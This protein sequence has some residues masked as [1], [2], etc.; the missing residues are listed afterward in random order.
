MLAAVYH[1]PNDIRVENVP[2]PKIGKGELLV[3]VL[4]ASIC[5][6]DLRIF[7]GSHRMYTP[8]TIRIPG[9]EVVGT[10]AEAG[11]EVNNYTIGQR[12]FCAPNT[13]CGRC[14]Q[15]VTGDNNLCASYDAIGVTSDGGFAEYVRIPANSVQQGN[16]IPVSETIDPAVAALMEPF[17]CVL[18]GQNALYIK[19]GEV[20]LIIGAGPIGVMHTKLAKARGA[21]RVIVSEPI[22]ERAAQVKRMGAD[23]VVD[24]ATEDLKSVLLQESQ[25]RGA[26]VIIVAAP[27][28]VAQES[29]L[30]LAAISGRI[31][32]FG[33]LPKDRPTINFDSNLVHY[34]EL[35]ITATT[36]CSTADCWQATQIIN[37]GLVDLS[38]VVSQRFPLKDAVMAF[39]A[40][41][42]R[43]SLKIILEP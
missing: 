13:G 3:K 31:N 7:H 10:I 34:K 6:T 18:R 33:G 9:H 36:A 28:H 40:A 4:S 8:G 17:A 14:L 24:P 16:V 1:G 32:F 12:V 43:K 29:A 20:V 25:G 39:A 26:D 30:D 21:G 22:A 5:G 27:V 42:D 15:C 37:S 41:E 19:P 38:D 11:A 35:V 23:R 2:V